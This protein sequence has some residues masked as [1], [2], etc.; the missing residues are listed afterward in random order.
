MLEPL[1][2]SISEL[3]GDH[4][5]WWQELRSW[6]EELKSFERR[7]AAVARPGADPDVLARLEQ[8]QNRLIREQ[9]VIDES[10]HL[11]KTHE[12]SLARKTEELP[13]VAAE[14]GYRDHSILRERMTV[15]EEL[16]KELRDELRDW[17][18]QRFRM[19][20]DQMG[21]PP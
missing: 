10:Q 9:E 1:T 21:G 12:D 5:I 18:A 4:L 14:A 19:D 11:I 6:Q 2:H 15:A 20:V 17:L 13:H 16:H 8:Y 7:L 3:H